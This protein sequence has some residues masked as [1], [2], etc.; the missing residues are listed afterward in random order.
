MFSNGFSSSLKLDIIEYSGR[1]QAGS[2]VGFSSRV[3]KWVLKCSQ[4]EYTRVFWVLKLSIREYSG[5][6]QVGFS[7]GF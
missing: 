5:R 3:L 1:S 2:H 7:S 4:V 6:S